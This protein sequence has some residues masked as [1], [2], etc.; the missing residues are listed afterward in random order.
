MKERYEIRIFGLLGPLLRSRFKSLA[1]QA[2]PCQS[3]LRGRLS[4][5]ELDQLLDRLDKSGLE[6]IYL[7]SVPG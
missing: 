1:C 5:E 4:T 3:T 6:V 2:L 7:D